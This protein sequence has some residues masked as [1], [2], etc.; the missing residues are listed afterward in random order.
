MDAEFSGDCSF[1]GYQVLK[2]LSYSGFPGAQRGCRKV[3]KHSGNQNICLKQ[4][5]RPR[6]SQQARQSAA[7]THSCL[8]HCLS[9]VKGPG[10]KVLWG[11]GHQKASAKQVNTQP[12]TSCADVSAQRNP[13]ESRVSYNHI[14]NRLWT[15]DLS[16]MLSLSYS[17]TLLLSPSAQPFQDM[18]MR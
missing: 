7:E 17:P 11:E 4:K 15:G 12:P 16:P 14:W 9:P 10:H 2:P 1:T 8:P 3:A 18:W 6:Q 5:L 13:E